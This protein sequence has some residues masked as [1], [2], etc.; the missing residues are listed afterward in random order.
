ME[1]KIKDYKVSILID[2]YG[3]LLTKRQNDI[4]RDYYDMDMSLSE[5][6]EKYNIARQT[7]KDSIKSAEKSLLLYEQKLK[8]FEKYKKINDYT[9]ILLEENNTQNID[10]INKIKAIIGY[11]AE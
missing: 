2:I 11:T 6:S 3:N 4:I 1:N 5:L 10:I 7:A 9:E 8:L